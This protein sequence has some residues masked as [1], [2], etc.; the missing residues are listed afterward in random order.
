MRKRGFTLIELL[1]VIAII[2]ILAAI[3]LPALSR[4]REAAN[5]ATCQNN[6]KQMGV[7][8]KMF[9]GE[10]KGI[11]PSMYPDYR[12]GYDD[13]YW[14]N[15]NWIDVYPEYLTDYNVLHCPSTPPDEDMSYPDFAELRGVNTLWRNSNHPKLKAIAQTLYDALG[16][17]SPSNAQNTVVDGSPDLKP[18]S[19]HE[20]QWSRYCAPS[21]FYDTYAYTGLVAGPE[22]ISSVDNATAA[23]DAQ[24]VADA[25]WAHP[26]SEMYGDIE[27]NTSTAP[28][29]DYPHIL[30][31]MREGVERFLITDINNTASSAR[32]QSRILCQRDEAFIDSYDPVTNAAT[33]VYEFNHIPGGCNVLYMDGHVEFIKYPGQLGTDTWFLTPPVMVTSTF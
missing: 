17:E 14:T 24:L 33:E 11:F 8:F 10:N 30:L 9:A 27:V 20:P 5:R 29:P 31:H 2:G 21:F 26:H 18:E 22:I 23:A 32:A 6:L 25:I 28:D 4:A 16:A 3:L 19:C 13:D 12:N 15:V 1:V 7:V